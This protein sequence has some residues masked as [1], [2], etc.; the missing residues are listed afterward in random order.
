MCCYA[1]VPIINIDL[2]VTT[3]VEQWL[4]NLILNPLTS[5]GSSLRAE[6]STIWYYITLSQSLWHSTINQ[7]DTAPICHLTQ[8]HLT[9]WQ[10][11]HLPSDTAPICHLI[12]QVQS[13]YKFIWDCW[14]ISCQRKFAILVSGHML[15][16]NSPARSGPANLDYGVI[17]WIV[18]ASYL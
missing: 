11:T 3:V 16:L 14:L 10:S 17:R 1:R 9:T 2:F 6:Y 12:H 7:P 5:M 18:S 13:H 8:H 4:T 15:V